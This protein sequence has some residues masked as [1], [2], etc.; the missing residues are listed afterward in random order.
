MARECVSGSLTGWVECHSPNQN[1]DQIIGYES[2]NVHLSL[3]PESDVGDDNNGVEGSADGN[4]VFPSSTAVVPAVVPPGYMSE[5][6]GR[7]KPLD[8]KT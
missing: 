7:A 5:K 1:I 8:R 4:V 6:G 3:L 2:E